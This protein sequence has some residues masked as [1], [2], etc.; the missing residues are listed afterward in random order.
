MDGSKDHVVLNIVEKKTKNE[1]WTNLTTLYQG[2]FVQQKILLH[3]HMRMFQMH[4]GE[5]IYPFLFILWTI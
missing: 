1:V 4:K 5:E 2:S 3:N